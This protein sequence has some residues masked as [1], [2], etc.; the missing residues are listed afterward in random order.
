MPATTRAALLV[1][2]GAATVSLTAGEAAGI[3]RD[4]GSAAVSLALRAFA[5][6]LAAGTSSGSSPGAAALAVPFVS[7]AE[8]AAVRW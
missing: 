6:A 3:S 1:D 5:V 7:E 2:L 4:A 8:V